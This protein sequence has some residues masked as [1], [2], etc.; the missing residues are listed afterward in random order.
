MSTMEGPALWGEIGVAQ[1]ENLE[2]D[3]PAH[4]ED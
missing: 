2:S 4:Q 3:L 1:P